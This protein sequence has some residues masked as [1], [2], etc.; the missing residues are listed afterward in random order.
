MNKNYRID[1]RNIFCIERLKANQIVLV[2]YWNLIEKLYHALFC[3]VSLPNRMRLLKTEESCYRWWFSSLVKN[4][5]LDRLH[6][7]CLQLGLECK[8]IV[9][10]WKHWRENQTKRGFLLVHIR[11][12]E[13]FYY[14][15]LTAVC[16]TKINFS[17]LKLAC[18]MLSLCYVW[19]QSIS[20]SV[21]L[22]LI[23]ILLLNDPLHDFAIWNVWS[24]F[25]R[26]VCFKF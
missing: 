17:I 19:F 23:K 3:Y 20:R 5:H 7:F 15:L 22:Y 13:K 18:S 25:F 4:K 9:K 24:R 2:W 6:A 8:M 11:N 21:L 16:E 10:I 1:S 26:I 14:I 12:N